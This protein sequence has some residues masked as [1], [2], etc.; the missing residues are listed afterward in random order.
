M[1]LNMNDLMKEAQKMQ[2]KMQAAQQK[3]SQLE[4]TGEAGAGLVKITM[5]GR[6]DIRPGGIYINPSLTDD[7]EM[8]ID[9]LVAAHADVVRKIEKIS[10]DEIASITATLP[11]DLQIP[12]QE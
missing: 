4:A 3:L 1:A 5:N 8:L 12:P 9:L 10:K 7:L 6:H 11:K 2:Q